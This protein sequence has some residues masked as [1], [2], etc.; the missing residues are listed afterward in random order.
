MGFDIK[1][2]VYECVQYKSAVEVQHNV[3]NSRYRQVGEECCL[4]DI[5]IIRQYAAAYQDV[6]VAHTD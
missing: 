3:S 2:A 6:F 5:R 4:E 1:L